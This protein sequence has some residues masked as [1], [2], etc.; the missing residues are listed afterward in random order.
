MKIALACDHGGLNLKNEIKKY[1]EKNNYEVIDFGTN[2]NE[3][4]DYPDY[5][6]KAAKSV[7]SGET[8]CGILVC[9]TG[10]GIG[11]AANKVKGIRCATL[12]DTFSARMTKAHN[13]ANMIALGERVTGIGL[14]IDI[15]DAYLNSSFEGGRH[16]KRV[17]KISA[18][19]K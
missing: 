8:E 12:G 19:E 17:D 16:Q 4:V 10:I 3:S 15:V 2:S 13:D 6:E 1:L 14:G 5:A 9:G 18:L 7:A 11:I